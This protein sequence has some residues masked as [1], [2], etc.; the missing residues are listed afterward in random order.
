MGRVAATS[1][2]E[3]GEEVAIQGCSTE[4]QEPLCGGV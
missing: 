2:A 3:G 4:G 1:G